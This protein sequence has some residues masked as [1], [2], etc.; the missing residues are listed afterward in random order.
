MNLRWS[1][2]RWQLSRPGILGYYSS[3]IDEREA[4]KARQIDQ[5]LRGAN[6]GDL[7]NVVELPTRF[8]YVLSLSTVQALGLTIPHNVAA[9]VTEWAQ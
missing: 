1:G 3:Q 6:P 8:Y 4:I 7:L 5:L 9:Q 2:L